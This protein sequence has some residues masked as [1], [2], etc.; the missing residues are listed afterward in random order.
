M[1]WSRVITETLAPRPSG[2][3]NAFGLVNKA[4]M[5][6]Y[7]FQIHVINNSKFN[8]FYTDTKLL[9]SQPTGKTDRDVQELC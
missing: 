1:K 4:F 3:Q 7:H 2:G 6:T 9:V 5:T 8:F